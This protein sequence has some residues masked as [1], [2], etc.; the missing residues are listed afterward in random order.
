MRISAQLGDLESRHKSIGEWVD[1]AVDNADAAL[2]LAKKDALRT[3]ALYMVQQSMEA[4]TKAL[5]RSA[6]MSHKEIWGHNNLELFMLYHQKLIIDS[7]SEVYINHMIST[8]LRDAEGYDVMQHLQ[9]MLLLLPSPSKRRRKKAGNRL[10]ES[11]LTTSQTE[12]KSLLD[13]LEELGRAIREAP[14]LDTLKNQLTNTQFSLN[15]SESTSDPARS[16]IDQILVQTLG[17]IPDKQQHEFEQMLLVEAGR[18]I[19]SEVSDHSG[20]NI[21]FSGDEILSQLYVSLVDAQL[22][23]FGI[24]IIGSLAWPHATYPRYPA[25]PDA[26]DS[27]QQAVQERNRGNLGRGHYTEE[28]GVIKHIEPLTRRA[29]WTADLLKKCYEAGCYSQIPALGAIEDHG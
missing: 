25:A 20:G 15:V 13:L 11:A 9:N 12:V 6:G 5:A 21:A 19:A 28:I 14:V 26:P 4:A 7:G 3:Q 8:Y 22:V 16:V 27:L 17:T 24:L 10:F 2:L 23:N 29:K 1:L 18:M